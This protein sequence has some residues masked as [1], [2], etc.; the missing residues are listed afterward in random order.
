M[1]RNLLATGRDVSVAFAIASGAS[2]VQPGYCRAVPVMIQE[3]EM[4]AVQNAIE[5][6]VLGNSL[7][8]RALETASEVP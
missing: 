1:K 6:Y 8:E 4:S 2:R 7:Q 3:C 5:D